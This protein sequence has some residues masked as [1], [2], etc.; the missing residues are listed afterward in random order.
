MIHICTYT[1]NGPY[2]APSRG[3]Y[4]AA[5]LKD[6]IFHVRLCM[7]DN[8]DLISIWKDDECLG[9]WRNEYEGV[10]DGEGGW[11]RGES[12]YI[13][14]RPDCKE[15]WLFSYMKRKLTEGAAPL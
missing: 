14:H 6:F 15:Q 13:L 4:Q 10:P 3:S 12:A 11:D 5:R 9:I 8:E 2:F 1:D 7:E